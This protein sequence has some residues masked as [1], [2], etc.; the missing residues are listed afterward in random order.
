MLA[1]PVAAVAEEAEDAA[2]A[3]VVGSAAVGDDKARRVCRKKGERER[4]RETK[5][6]HNHRNGS[7]AKG[8]QESCYCR[9][10]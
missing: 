6:V 7:P 2:A 8:P 5:L 9:E 10:T 3:A 4:E 1:L